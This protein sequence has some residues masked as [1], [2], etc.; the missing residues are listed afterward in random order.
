VTSSFFP[1]ASY[2]FSPADRREGSFFLLPFCASRIFSLLSSTFE[3]KV[4]PHAVLEVPR[5]RL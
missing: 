5:S 4:D 2:I 1:Y 3:K